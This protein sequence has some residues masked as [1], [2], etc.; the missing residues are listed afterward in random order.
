MS[1]GKKK[2]KWMKKAFEGSHGQFRAKAEAAGESTA[3]YAKEKEGAKGL[4]GKQARLAKVGM[5][6][7]HKKARN[8]MY[9][10]KE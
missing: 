7:N 10:S 9:G 3:E 5:R 8:S 6:A 1:D 4:L 2:K